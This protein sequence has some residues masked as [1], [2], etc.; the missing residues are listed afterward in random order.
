MP[1]LIFE[2]ARGLDHQ[3]IAGRM[4]QHLIDQFEP[5]DVHDDDRKARPAPRAHVA[6]RPSSRSMK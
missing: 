5:H 6:Q 1:M 3:F 4:T 2:A